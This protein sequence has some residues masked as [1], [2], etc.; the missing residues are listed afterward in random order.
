MRTAK[1]PT[2]KSEYMQRLIQ[3][4]N[5]KDWW[6]VPPKDPRSYSKRGKFLSSMFREAEF[7]GRPNDTPEH[8]TIRN[9]VVGDEATI[10][11]I[12]LGKPAVHNLDAENL[13]EEQFAID[14]ELYKAGRTTGYD[15]IVL[16]SPRGYTRFKAEGRIPLSIELNLLRGDWE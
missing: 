8:V 15:A 9:P 11:T 5:R 14:A 3:R 1:P 13:A 12:L 6:H 16:L 7:Y 2:L 4:I 10:E